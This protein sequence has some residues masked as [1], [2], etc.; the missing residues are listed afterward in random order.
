MIF[1]KT[2]QSSKVFYQ[3]YKPEMLNDEELKDG[4]LLPEI[5]EPKIREGKVS[6]LYFSTERG[7]WYEYIDAPIDEATEIEQLKASQQ[8]QDDLLINILLGRV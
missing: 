4:Y 8:E 3:H 6:I 1:I 2:E 5:P 7:V